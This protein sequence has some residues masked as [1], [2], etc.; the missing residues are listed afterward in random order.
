MEQR[1]AGGAARVEDDA[2]V[3]DAARAA[4]PHPSPELQR[5]GSAVVGE[6]G[7]G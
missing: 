1:G 7:W 5:G 6:D 2:G 3:E 4:G